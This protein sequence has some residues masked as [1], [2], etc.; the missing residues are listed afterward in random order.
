MRALLSTLVAKRR[1]RTVEFELP[2]IES[3]ADVLKTSS[4]VIS[5]CAAGELSPR[6]AS[7]F[8]ELISSR[9]RDVYLDGIVLKRS[10]AGEI[11]NVSLLVAI[12]VNGEGY[13]EILGICEGAKEDKAGWSAFLKHLKERG[14]AGIRLIVSDACL[15]LAE[16]LGCRGGSSSLT[17]PEVRPSA[18]EA[19][20]AIAACGRSSEPFRWCELAM[21]ENDPGSHG[22]PRQ[23]L[24]RRLLIHPALP[25]DLLTNFDRCDQRCEPLK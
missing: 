17:F 23:P 14:L 19:C 10:W 11:R 8:M 4:A 25:W 21:E 20:F 24:L 13:R 22:A 9:V 12:S 1:E 3:V 18:I 15:G 5:A 2:K 16:P 7:E 6:E